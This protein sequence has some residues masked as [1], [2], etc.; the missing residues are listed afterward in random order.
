MKD[1]KRKRGRD[2]IGEREKKEE[3]KG[4]NVGIEPTTSYVIYPSL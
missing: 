2:K 4:P 3:E 1:N